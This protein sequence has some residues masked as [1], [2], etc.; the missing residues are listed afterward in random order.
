MSASDLT[1]CL[2]VTESGPIDRVASTAEGN[3]TVTITAG[4]A[5]V[6][7]PIIT[8]TDDSTDNRNSVV[9]LTALAPADSN[10]SQTGYNVSVD[11]ASARFLIED[12]ERTALTLSSEDTTMVEGDASQTA[13]AVV[14]LGRRLYA[15]ELIA[16]GLRLSTTTDARLPDGDA[17]T[18]EDFAVS[19][20]GEGVTATGL[21]GAMP[22]LTFAG[23]DTNA[24]RTATLTF[25]PT[26]GSN[27]GDTTDEVVRLGF[28][29]P[30]SAT[31]V[32]GGGQGSG[33]VNL[34]LADDDTPGL[35]FDPTA[36]TVAEGGSATYTVALATQPTGNV[37]VTVS[38]ASG[39]VSVDTDGDMDND[40]S[41]LTFTDSTWGTAQTVTVSAGQD[42][43]STND[44]ATLTHSASGGYG[45]A[46]GTVAVTVTDDDEPVVTISA[47]A[48][49]TEGGAAT[50]TITATPAPA[51]ALSVTVEVTDDS[52]S[53]FLATAQE[54]TRTVTVPTGGSVAV[55]VTTMQDQI[56]E[57][58]G[59]VTARVAAGDGYTVGSPASATVTVADDDSAPPPPPVTDDDDDDPPA[60]VVPA[61]RISGGAGVTEGGDATFTLMTSPPPPAPLRVTVTVADGRVSDFLAASQQGARTVTVSTRG[62]ADFIV[63][64]TQDRADEAD[65]AVTATVVAGVGYTTGSPAS[66]SVTVTDDD[67]PALVVSSAALAPDEGAAATYTVALGAAPRGPVTLAVT[68]SDGAGVTVSPQRLTFT[69]EDWD[70]AQTVTV[71]ALQDADFADESGA[72][73]HTATGGGYAGVTATITVTVTDDDEPALVVSSA[74]LA[75]DEGAAA[76]YTVA[77]G[78]APRGPVT[79]AVTVSDGAGVTVSPQRL[80]F[81]AE[82]WDT[83]Q[84]VTVTALQDADFA[85]E[86]GALAHTATGGG[87][88]GV[89]AT[90]TVTVT[91][92]DEPPM[93]DTAETVEAWLPRFGRVVAEQLI[94]GVGDRLAARTRAGTP[95]PEAGGFNARL[96]GQ[97]LGAA[98]AFGDCAGRDPDDRP[99]QPPTAAAPTAVR[100]ALACAPAGDSIVYDRIPA[101]RLLRRA[102]ANA[103]FDAS[104]P[105]GRGATWGLW[106][107]GAVTALDGRAGAIA[108]EGDVL[109]GQLGADVSVGR[110]WVLGVSASYS[111]GQGDYADASGRGTLESTLTALTPYLG[112][113]TERLTAWGA[114][115]VGQGDTA[116]TPQQ[117]AAVQSELDL[118]LGAAGVRSEALDFGNGVS[119]A[120]LADAM[121]LHS[122]TDA[123]PGQP[124]ISAAVRRVRAAVEAAYTHPLV[125]G[126]HFSARFEGGARWDDGDAEQ[127]LGGEVSGGVAWLGNGLTL[128]LEGRHLIVHED[129]D[130]SQTGAS[131]HL[132]WDA[133]D[134]GGLGPSLSVRRQWGVATDAGLDSLF[135]LSHL[136][137]LGP[138][139]GAARFD[140]EVGWGRPLFGGR[141]V[142]TP[143]LLHGAQRNA[144]LHTLGWRLRPLRADGAGPGFNL[145]LELA[146]RTDSAGADY[147]LL[148]KARL[149]Y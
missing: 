1:V 104:G 56:D 11:D 99:R 125:A 13:T 62:T 2:S 18:P 92:D 29:L 40:Q 9:T 149:G 96:A 137:R 88:A 141:F 142:G 70:T 27:D 140:A 69:A 72:L 103:A 111:Q 63:T 145:A 74:A 33:S 66:A 115:S 147:S 30:G 86:S 110:D 14:T 51:A 136:G 81:T 53:D 4:S 143:F 38:G 6:N 78:A 122:T 106:G 17:A 114:L 101:G 7:Y 123:T 121:A 113:T 128:E 42:N 57:V 116:L 82:D 46:T 108:L 21:D 93:L 102:L 84:T 138:E 43:D 144:R 134:A 130:F 135:A 25:T 16:Y 20:T 133:W 45:S 75:P 3:Q 28:G 49:V 97:R 41:T 124:A 24:V 23:D 127:G 64:T 94:E 95:A 119:V 68:V 36:L 76:T 67:E 117:G 105:T 58:N 31:N 61:V 59:T 98:A 87:Y 48:G 79:L 55:T 65:G 90:I 34:A 44:T 120:L 89:T 146:R 32:G 126:G 15:G 112:V 85:D 12:N 118:Q 47:G 91:D 39:E 132:A 139:A 52:A 100:A 26:A 73:A 22:T 8:W 54:G 131:A 10:C 35:V 5:D 19:V 71:T 37:T 129:D 60:P 109:T 50:F 77:L 107:R 83:A 80:T 148:L